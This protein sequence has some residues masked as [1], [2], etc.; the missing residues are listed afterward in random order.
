ML[1]NAIILLSI[2]GAVL[3][4]EVH[5]K[6]GRI[7]SGQVVRKDGKVYVSDR[8]AKYV[9]K[10]SEVKDVVPKQSFMDE[11]DEKLHKLP[12]DDPEAIYEFGLWLEE[13]EWP[14][15][16]TRCYERV[17]EIDAD[18]RGARRKLGYKLYEGEW[19]SPDELKKKKGL[20][21]WEVDGKWYTKHDLATIKAQ[22]EKNEKFRQQIEKQRKVNKKVQGILTKFATFDKKKRTVA[23]Q[24][25]YSYAEELNSPQMRKFADDT[26]AYYDQYVRHL[27]A[28]IKSRT[29]VHATM[30]KLKKPIQTFE[31]NLGAAVGGIFPAQTPVRI[32]LPEISIASV[33][34]TVDIPA[35]CE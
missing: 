20:V 34:T 1:R 23:Y 30:T 18:H 4:D 8:D 3:A 14:S 22:I 11:F 21:Q 16:A 5:L 12:N 9:L 35:G 24:E 2:A 28:Q 19:V 17:I 10:E 27:C 33:S 31:T 26:K 32:Q 29:E 25:L 7:L 13:N 15:R 6:D